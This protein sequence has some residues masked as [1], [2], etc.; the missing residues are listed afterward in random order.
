MEVALSFAGPSL[1]AGLAALVHA[2]LPFLCVTTASAHREAAARPH[3]QPGAAAA[4]PPQRARA[5]N[6]MPAW[7]PVI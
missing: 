5:A 1:K 3:G 2:F 7:D 4:D 6:G